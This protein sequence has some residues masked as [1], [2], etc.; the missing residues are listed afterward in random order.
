MQLI[1]KKAI[2][3][4]TVLSVI[5]CCG[6]ILP[7]NYYKF[8][9][10]S[11]PTTATL[12]SIYRNNV[13]AGENG[14]VYYSSNSG[15]N[16]TLLSGI[17]VKNYIS[18]NGSFPDNATRITIVGSGGTII[19]TENS[20]QTWNLQ[21]SGTT[22]DLYSV[23]SSLISSP[24]TIKRFAVGSGG[25]IISSTYQSGTNWSAWSQVQSGVVVN[26]RSVFFLGSAG[27][28]CGDGGIILKTT[29]QGAT[30]SPKTS[31]TSQRLNK[32]Y[33]VDALT[34]FAVGNNGVIIRSTDGG[35]S[36]AGVASNTNVNLY[37]IFPYFAVGSG[38]KCLFSSDNGLTWDSIRVTPPSF[39]DFYSV[40]IGATAVGKDGIIYKTVTDSSYKCIYIQPN[41]IRAFFTGT[42]IFN[43]NILNTNFGGF[44]WPSSTNNTAVF[45]TGLTIAAMVNDSLRFMSC[46]YRGEG[47]PGFI[48]SFIPQTNLK[49]Y[50]YKVSRG[51]S[52][53]TNYD[54]LYWGNMVPFGAPFVDVNNNG[55]YEYQ[56]DTPGV[57]GASSTLFVCYTDGFPETH[58]GG[59]GMGGGTAP[60]GAEIHLTAWGYSQPSY[61]DMQF[62]KFEVIN[63]SN[64]PWTKTYFGFFCDPD[65]GN[66][67]TDYIGCDTVRKL[68]Y[69]YKGVAT[70][71]V[72]GSAPPA[73]GIRLL[74]TPYRKYVSPYGYL[75][76]T[77]FT[78]IYGGGYADPLCE[79]LHNGSVGGYLRLKGYKSDSTCWLDPTYNPPKKTRIIYPGDPETNTGWTEYQGRIKNC[80]LDS[81]GELQ[82][83]SQPFDMRFLLSSGA[84]NLTV[85]PGDTQTIIIS[86]LIAQGLNNK[87]SVTK[88]KNLSDIAAQFYESGF[89]IG[90]R[91]GESEIPAEYNLFQN[92]PNPF[93]PVTNIMF[94]L[95]QDNF[96]E[97]KIFDIL[98]RE[99]KTLINS[100][101]KR[102]NY[103]TEFDASDFSSGIYFCSMK[104]GKFVSVKKMILIR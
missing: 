52:Y 23:A 21:A 91:T 100:F 79:E 20:F 80:N 51:D 13:I 6:E 55:T 15:A 47:K 92:Y 66:S 102:G 70:D 88:L 26:L 72:Y 68:G 44:I 58:N 18:I 60:L 82:V 63:K 48:S 38:G 34:G 81:T 10:V 42:G 97:I 36:W 77:A 89:V 32:I 27:W 8:I 45:T 25:I 67:M 73:Y 28:I 41:N 43:Q 61:S 65:V 71:P 14:T 104:S 98:G 16:W 76:V 39:G 46:D 103:K 33:F 99:I 12:N 95:P 17:P 64:Q 40:D 19:A 37:S 5:F 22:A 87:N 7:Q 4:I 90:V 69:A 54:W 86:Q 24:L 57:K 31:G 9:S 2:F 56:I 94:T 93:N 75:P 11:S 59:S 78:N 49:F 84:D 1:M 62:L 96:V 29:D 85:A 30:W 3:I 101:M 50:M 35:N 53:L 83:P 74:K